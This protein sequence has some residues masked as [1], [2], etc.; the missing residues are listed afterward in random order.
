MLRKG[1][2]RGVCVARRS[3]SMADGVTSTV[4]HP[5]DVRQ[6]E[7]NGLEFASRSGQYSV[8]M[9]RCDSGRGVNVVC[10]DCQALLLRGNDDVST[11]GMLRAMEERSRVVISRVMFVGGQPTAN[12]RRPDQLF[13]SCEC[14]C[15]R[16]DD[17]QEWVAI[18]SGKDLML[19]EG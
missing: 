10:A 14:F 6:V 5:I 7:W 13:D 16:R 19:L 2:W 3:R 17:V 11:A 12:R 15:R 8:D 4:Y 18:R 1:R 9:S